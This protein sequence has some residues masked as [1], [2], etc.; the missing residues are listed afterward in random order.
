VEPVTDFPFSCLD[1]LNVPC[2]KEELGDNASLIS[3]PQL[4]SNAKKYE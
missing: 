3:I 4:I 2:D 1:M